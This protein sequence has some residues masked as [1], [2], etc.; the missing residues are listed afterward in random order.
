M[1][2]EIVGLG[3]LIPLLKIIADPE[4]L[5]DP[6]VSR[7]LTKL[8]IEKDQFFYILLGITLLTNLLKTLLLIL[9]NYKQLKILN[10]NSD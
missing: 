9:L 2:F 6:I 7:I 3:L 8:T 10:N 1:F 4:F 5:N